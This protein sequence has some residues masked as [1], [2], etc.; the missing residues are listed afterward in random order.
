VLIGRDF[1]PPAGRRRAAADPYCGPISRIALIANPGSG[2][3]GEVDAGERLAGFGFEVEQLPIEEAGAAADSGAERIV[4]AGGDGSIAPAALAAARAAV[5]LAVI[6]AGTAN[7]FAERMGLPEQIE[8]AIELAGR[9]ERTRRV[10]LAGAGG[11][12]F[13]NVASLGL[14]P[15]AAEAADELKSSLGALAYTVGALRAAGGEDPVNCRVECDGEVLYE[16]EAWQVT[17]GCTGAFGGGSRIDADADDGRLDVVVIEGGPRALLAKHAVGLRTGSLEDQRGVV[18]ARG[19]EI[20]VRVG[21]EQDLNIDGEVVPASEL[22][23]DDGA[24][25]FTVTDSV[26]L[27]VG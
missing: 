17:V 24:L 15:A 6:P 27:V 21:G 25:A 12:P 5:P 19:V 4:V 11:R 7:D 1:T 3:A 22:R 18:S 26:E 8:A 16:G 10:D 9:G 23:D 2:A 14:P 20:A 13:L